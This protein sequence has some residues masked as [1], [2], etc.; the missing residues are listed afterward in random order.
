MNVSIN[1]KLISVIAKVL[2]SVQPPFVTVHERL[3]IFVPT[4]FKSFLT[5]GVI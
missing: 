1:S 2:T 5:G 4:L 3:E